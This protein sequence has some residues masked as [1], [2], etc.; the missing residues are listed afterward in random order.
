MWDRGYA[1]RKIGSTE[2]HRDGLSLAIRTTAPPWNLYFQGQSQCLETA[3]ADGPPRSTHAISTPCEQTQDATN[4]AQ[5]TVT[6]E[7]DRIL[8]A[9][10]F[11]GGD[12]SGH[13]RGTGRATGQR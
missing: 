10:T 7:A 2:P 9:R 12:Y 4:V 11:V 13:H 8:I 5:S 1:I 3:A 6:T